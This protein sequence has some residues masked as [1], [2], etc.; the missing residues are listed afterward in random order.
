MLCHSVGGGT[1]SGLGSLLVQE[2]R[3]AYPRHYLTAAALCHYKATL[4]LSNLQEFTDATLTFPTDGV[5][6]R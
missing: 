6:G 2:V 3:D 1:G 5:N 4:A